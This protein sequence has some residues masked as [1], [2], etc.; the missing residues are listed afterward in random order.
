M[1]HVGQYGI[2]TFGGEGRR[3]SNWVYA[4]D[5]DTYKWRQVNTLGV[6][7][8][9]LFMLFQENTVCQSWANLGAK[10]QWIHSWGQG[11]TKLLCWPQTML[12][13]ADLLAARAENLLQLG[14]D[15]N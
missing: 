2:Y 3:L 10:E 5:P 6:S 4:L 1:T 11:I 8:T 13:K 12:C 14:E 7:S 9:S 15:A